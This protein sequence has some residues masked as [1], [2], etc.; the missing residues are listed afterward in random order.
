MST[1]VNRELAF[2]ITLDLELAPDHDLEEQREILIRL[3]ADLA[4]L[5][6]KVTVFVTAEAAECFAVELR[7]WIRAGH[8]I[9]CHG[10]AHAREEDYRRASTGQARTWIAAASRRIELALG[11]RPRCFR[12]PRME[13]SASTQRA[14]V[15]ERYRADFSVCPGRCDAFASQSYTS[16]WLLAPR[17]PYRP[18]WDSPFRRGELPLWVVP[19]SAL[20][21]PF[22]SGLR[23]LLGRRITAR[24]ADFL[25]HEARRREGALVYLFH[26]YEFTR[27]TARLDR[28]PLHQRLYPRDPEWRYQANRS[29]L[30]RVLAQPD[31]EAVTASAF[32]RRL[33]SPAPRASEESRRW[34]LRRAG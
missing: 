14:L 11:V 27:R 17:V 4:A 31:V 23:Y 26:S 34:P 29:L 5:G 6:A 15:A 30:A 1:Q 16:R 33:E 20:G 22:S 24:L 13:T 28:R 3:R 25:A 18:S 8:E 2:L 21:A 9:G 19:S 12:G 10:V 7:R 32:L